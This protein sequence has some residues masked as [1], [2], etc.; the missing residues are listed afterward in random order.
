M[1]PHSNTVNGDMLNLYMSLTHAWV[2]FYLTWVTLIVVLNVPGV[3]C[4][5]Q[6]HQIET[7]QDNDVERQRE[8]IKRQYIEAFARTG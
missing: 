1:G 2:W 8:S 5:S 7:N 4:I 6:F 3:A